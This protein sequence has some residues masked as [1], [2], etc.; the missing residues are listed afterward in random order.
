MI[1]VIIITVI[2]LAA[3]NAIAMWIMCASNKDD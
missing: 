3:L 2:V 1:K